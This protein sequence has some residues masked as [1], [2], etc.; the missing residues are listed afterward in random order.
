MYIANGRMLRRANIIFDHLEEAEQI[1][2]LV[3]KSNYFPPLTS[4]SRSQKRID[5][6]KETN[7]GN[8]SPFLIGTGE[9][10]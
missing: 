5:V 7:E 2:R 6:H 9:L 3:G 1:K 4:R 10:K 8:C